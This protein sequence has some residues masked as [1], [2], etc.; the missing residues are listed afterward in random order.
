MDDDSCFSD[1]RTPTSRITLALAFRPW[2]WG[3]IQLAGRMKR[4][5]LHGGSRR[6]RLDSCIYIRY[7]DN[8]NMCIYI[9]IDR[10]VY[11]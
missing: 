10:Y 11:L 2:S 7:I 3:P 9:Y 1:Y 6:R 4:S 8:Y 5:L